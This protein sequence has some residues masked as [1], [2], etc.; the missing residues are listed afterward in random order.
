MTELGTKG[1]SVVTLVITL[2]VTLVTTLVVS[3]EF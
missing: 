1:A 2:V 3:W